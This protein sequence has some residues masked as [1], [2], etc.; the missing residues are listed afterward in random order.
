[1][2]ADQIAERRAAACRAFWSNDP[3]NLYFQ[4]ETG[5]SSFSLKEF[6]QFV[7]LLPHDEFKGI[8]SC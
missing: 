5:K 4:R 3:L 2:S 8:T 1:M 7:L 6:I